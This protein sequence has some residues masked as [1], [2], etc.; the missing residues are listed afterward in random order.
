MEFEVTGAR[1]NNLITQAQFGMLDSDVD[2]IREAIASGGSIDVTGL[3]QAGYQGK[4]V[5]LPDV[6][7]YGPTLIMIALI[8]A[9]WYVIVTWNEDSNKLIVPM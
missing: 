8:M 3:E 9:L 1:L 5:Y 4:Y 6:M 7:D 2:E